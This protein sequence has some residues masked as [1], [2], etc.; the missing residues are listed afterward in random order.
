MSAV[1]ATPQRRPSAA[2]GIAS[3]SSATG[4]T[5]AVTSQPLSAAQQAALRRLEAWVR[6]DDAAARPP[7]TEESAAL[8]FTAAE[9]HPAN[10]HAS[11]SGELPALVSHPAGFAPPGA[12]AAVRTAAE[13][14]ALV[15]RAERQQTV[16]ALAADRAA[17]AWLGAQVAAVTVLA[18]SVGAARAALAAEGDR[19]RS[20]LRDATPVMEAFSAT[21]AE[22]EREAAAAAARAA[23]L[24]PIED[25]RA[26]A[27]TLDA[28][29]GGGGPAHH[30]SRH[31][32][33][34]ALA[35]LDGSIEHIK[36]RHTYPNP[37]FCGAPTSKR[38]SRS[39]YALPTLP[40]T[41]GPGRVLPPRL[42]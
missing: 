40:R 21:A 32:L 38:A 17:V 7:A 4:A 30:D 34:R 12:I 28:A 2:A 3:P 22:R 39:P 5:A 14:E 13:L 16:N 20:S 35:T 23:Q 10:G 42:L 15:L 37:R 41:G 8:L 31:P 11:E 26:V 24:R 18:D 25:A 36:A 6:D 1:A 27:A 29:A 19:C 9:R 33:V